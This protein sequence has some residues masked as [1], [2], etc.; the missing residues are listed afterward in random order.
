ML[1]AEPLLETLPLLSEGRRLGWVL[2]QAG[3]APSAAEARR[4][5]AQNAVEIDGE[6]AANVLATTLP[7]SGLVKVGRRRYARVVRPDI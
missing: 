6:T 5:I 4:L 1:L 2:V 3:M 7:A